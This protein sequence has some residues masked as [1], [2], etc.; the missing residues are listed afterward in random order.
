MSQSATSSADRDRQTTILV[1]DSQSNDYEGHQERLKTSEVTPVSR[2]INKTQSTGGNRNEDNTI[3]PDSKKNQSVVVSRFL[4]IHLH[5]SIEIGCFDSVNDVYMKYSIVTGPDWILSSGSDVGITQISRYKKDESG[6]RKFVWNQPITISY[7]SYNY[8]GW[9]QIVL[10]VYYFNTFGND[11]ILGYGCSHL[12]VS[13][14]LPANFKQVVKIYAPQSSST[15]RQILSWIVGRKPE[16][17]DSNLFARAD[18]RSVLQMVHVGQVEL[19]FNITS[20]DV[21]NNGYRS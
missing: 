11:Q 14:R 2:N 1:N 3:G 19:A 12:P 13:S 8:F 10:S 5:G 4:S 16:L 9:P 6:A 18:C 17:V 21:S 20:K 15:I 7:R